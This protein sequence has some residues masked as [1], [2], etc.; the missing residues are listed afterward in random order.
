MD[1]VSLI[2]VISGL[3]LINAAIVLGG[4]VHNFLNIP[5]LM[6]VIG[7]TIAATLLTFQLKD[8][9]AAFKG[10]FVVFSRP[11]E[12]PGQ[13]ITTMLRLCKLSRQKGLMGLGQVKTQSPF[14]KRALDLIAEAADE[15]LIRDTLRTE[16][17]SM[18][19]RH[20]AAQEVFRRMG[21][22][23]PA[24][25]LL[26]T[27]IGL[28]QMLSELQAPSSIGPAMSLALLTTFYGSLLSTTLFLPI[29][30]RLKARTVVEVMT[31]EII[32][33]GAIGILHDNNS[34]SVYERLSSFIP[35][36]QRKPLSKLRI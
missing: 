32:F 17:E 20:F 6:I 19:M 23:A 3:A 9:S 35:A 26:G 10:A 1:L 7:G 24:F 34:I 28:V 11:G 21:M 33:E 25:G 29:A 31:L 15:R 16:I 36:E 27:L 30:G 12:S 18:K 22:Y 2:G 14:L 4:D 5:G 8:V 13:V